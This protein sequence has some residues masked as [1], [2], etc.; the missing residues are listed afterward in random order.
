MKVDNRICANARHSFKSA[1]PWIEKLC[2]WWIKLIVFLFYLK[3]K[4][5]LLRCLLQTT[6]ATVTTTVCTETVTVSTVH[7]FAVPF[8][9]RPILSRGTCLLRCTIQVTFSLFSVLEKQEV[10]PHNSAPGHHDSTVPFTAGWKKTGSRCGDGRIVQVRA[11]A[12]QCS[13]CN[14]S[15][16][17]FV[18]IAQTRYGDGKCLLVDGIAFITKKWMKSWHWSQLVWGAIFSHKWVTHMRCQPKA[19]LQNTPVK[20]AD[21]FTN[22][23]K[24][25]HNWFVVDFMNTGR[26][27]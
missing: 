26:R 13:K 16:I 12:H 23:V 17:T 3:K 25:A 9:T 21:S 6:T 8:K 10:Q 14:N 5:L 11:Y 20:P 2:K 19:R 18:D 15:D 22:A 1:P 27:K 7:C 4:K 24:L